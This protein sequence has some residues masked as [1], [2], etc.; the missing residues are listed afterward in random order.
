MTRTP[1]DPRCQPQPLDEVELAEVFGG[2]TATDD[3]WKWRRDAGGGDDSTAQ[4]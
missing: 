2:Y 3:L 1:T 4:W